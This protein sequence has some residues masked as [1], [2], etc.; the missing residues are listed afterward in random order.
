MTSTRRTL[1]TVGAIALLAAV[2]LTGCAE[3]EPLDSA[4]PSTPASPTVPDDEART[5]T[6][7][8]VSVTSAAPDEQEAT[9]A[10][11]EASQ[12]SE[13]PRVETVEASDGTFEVEIPEGWE[14]A[15]DLARQN[16]AEEQR[17]AIVLAAKDRERRDEFFT[18]VVVTREEYVG[19]LTSAVEDTAEQ[20]A[21]EDGEYELLDPVEVDGNQAPGYTV[22]REVNDTTIH[23]TQRWISH[24]GTLYSVTLSVVDSQVGDTADLLDEML[25]TWRWLD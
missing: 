23:Q 16:V 19:S 20:L 3:E 7:D 21:G 10:P 11:E 9:S 12:T 18:N 24:D 5:T 13:A 17:E 25:S 1:R 14:Q 4:P 15:L 22:V 8:A 6:P 2:V